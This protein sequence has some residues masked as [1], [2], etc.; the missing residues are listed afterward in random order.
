LVSFHFI[1]LREVMRD[2]RSVWETDS[3]HVDPQPVMKDITVDVCVIGGGIAGMTAAY[4]L[5]KVGRSILLLDADS[6]G[7]GETAHTT[8]H[9]AWVLDERF[10]QLAEIRGDHCKTLHSGESVATASMATNLFCTS[11]SS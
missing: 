4:R 8:A 11:S 2:T 9:L 3:P 10:S 5:L 1:P 6:P 7:R